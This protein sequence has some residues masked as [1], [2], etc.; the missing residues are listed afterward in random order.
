MSLYSSNYLDYKMFWIW[1]IRNDSISVLYLR[2]LYGALYRNMAEPMYHRGR[3]TEIKEYLYRSH[4]ENNCIFSLYFKFG[5]FKWKCDF[6][7][8]FLIQVLVLYFKIQ[9][10]WDGPIKLDCFYSILANRCNRS[11]HFKYIKMHKLI[12]FINGKG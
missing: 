3:W 1:R 2:Q 7:S 10:L 4:I 6:I 12:L 5:A 11:N 9:K 8:S